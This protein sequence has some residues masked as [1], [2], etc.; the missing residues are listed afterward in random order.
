MKISIPYNSELID[1]T[2]PEK[3]FAGFVEPQNITAQETSEKIIQAALANCSGSLSYRDIIDGPGSLLVIVNDGTRPTPTKYVLDVIADDLAKA[4][5]EFIIATGA[6]RGPT[7]EE[8]EFIFGRHY[9][10]FAGAVHVHDA[11][12]NEEMVFLGQSAQGTDMSINRLGY[13]ADKVLVIGSVEPHYF[14][15]YTGGRKAFLPGIASFSTIEKNHSYAVSAD[16]KT[17]QLEGNP[18]HLDMVDALKTLGNK[19]IFSIMTVMDKNHGIYCVTAGNINTSF[20]EAVDSANEVFTSKISEKADIVI[21]CAKYPMDI[22]LYQS[23]KAIDN[24]KLALKTD[25]ILILVASC[26]DGVGERAYIDLLSSCDTPAAVIEEIRSSYRLGYHKAAKMAE[27]CTWAKIWA[28]TELE[29]SL[30]ESIF[31]KPVSNLQDSVEKALLIKGA[32]AKVLIFPDG[33]VTVPLIR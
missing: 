24:G 31:I 33:A 1:I 3:H 16:A 25:G 17:L 23:Q 11:R 21:S 9:V 7:R 2:I 20:D 26:R 22:D 29:D 12:N 32:Y 28:K 8:Y 4:R 10:R 15:G 18:V 27:V 6:H 14:A 30:L 13:E 19:K 5:A